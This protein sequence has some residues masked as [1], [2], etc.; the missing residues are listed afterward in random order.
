HKGHVLPALERDLLVASAAERA[1]IRLLGAAGPL[2]ARLRPHAPRL[3]HAHFGTDGLLALPL[4]RA[5][6]I[7]LATTLHGFEVSRSFDAMFFSGR[8]SWSRYAV[9]KRRL[10]RS[11]DL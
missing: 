9:G 1:A 5:L 4:A 7:P 10:Q 6:G 11:G 2:A 8:L 3:I